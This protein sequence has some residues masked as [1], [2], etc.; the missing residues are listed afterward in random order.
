MLIHLADGD[1][2]RLAPYAAVR[3][4]D[5]VRGA[6]F[7][8]EGEVVV[9]VLVEKSPYRVIS[10]LV[11]ERRVRAI[12]DVIAKL[13]APVLVVSQ[14]IMDRVVGFAIHRG[15]LALG[16]RAPVPF[17]AAA[18]SC[19]VG[20][21]GLTNHDNVGGIFRNAAA[22][23]AHV[24]LDRATCDPLYRKAIRV[25][26]GAA[27][28]VPFVRGDDVLAML[29]ADGFEPIALSPRGDESI[30]ALGPGRFGLVLGTEGPGLPEHLLQRAR[31]VRIPMRPG[32]DSL[33]VAVAAGIALHRLGRIS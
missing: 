26:A 27:L 29:S 32:F 14:A 18:A 17:D 20:L 8:A 30:D 21:V 2:P 9:R 12:E 19:A 5:L 28:H 25:S 22:F 1:D 4:R 11:E 23:G 16:E 31:R 7:I 6:H 13:A 24:Y 33:N 3:E 10:L 15:I